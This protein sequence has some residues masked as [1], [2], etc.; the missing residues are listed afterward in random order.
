MT[1]Y[2]MLECDLLGCRERTNED[3]ASGWWRVEPLADYPGILA[4]GVPSAFGY[5][6]TEHTYCSVAHAV[7]GISGTRSGATRQHEG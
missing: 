7:M 5:G 1:V 6:H 3:M 2:S 4:S